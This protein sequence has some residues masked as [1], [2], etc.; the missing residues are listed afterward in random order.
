MRPSKNL[1]LQMTIP[2]QKK[3]SPQKAFPSHY[4]KALVTH[5]P[6]HLIA[7]LLSV[8]TQLFTSVPHP[9][10][11]LLPRLAWYFPLTHFR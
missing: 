8:V 9:I 3:S 1:G 4:R 5:V 10:H 7:K 6:T 11:L 2:E